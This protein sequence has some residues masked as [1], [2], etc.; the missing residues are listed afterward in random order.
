MLTIPN[1][2]KGYGPWN[3]QCRGK[4]SKLIK[5]IVAEVAKIV[6][7][8]E[9]IKSDKVILELSLKTKDEIKELN[10]KFM[11]KDEA[12]D[13]ISLQINDEISEEIPTILG[14][15]FFCLAIINEDAEYNQKNEFHH[16]AH[17]V[18]HAVLHILGFNHET[19]KEKQS[20]EAKEILIL[21]KLGV[22][23]PY[24]NLN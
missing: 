15:A 6:L 8:H 16:L 9:K 10:K 1:I 3:F 18:V 14:T 5:N 7:I 12:T 17:I 13:V 4:G 11:K 21:S 23:N 2:P 22:Q 24:L 19:D 20:M